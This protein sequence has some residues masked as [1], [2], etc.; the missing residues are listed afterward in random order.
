[1]KRLRIPVLSILVILALL[2]T[3]IPVPALALAGPLTSIAP[4]AGPV[5]TVVS[6]AG[7]GFTAGATDTIGWDGVPLTTTIIA[8]GGILAGAFTVPS[9]T[10]GVHVVSIIPPG[11]DT[12]T[13]TMNFTVAPSIVLSATTVQVGNSVAINGLGFGANLSVIIYVDGVTNISTSTTGTGTFSASFTVPVGAGGTHTVTVTDSAANTTNTTYNISPAVSVTPA[14]V[15]VGTQFT[16]SGSSFAASSA[17]T[18]AIDGANVTS[19]TTNTIGSFT[20]SLAA[21]PKPIGVHTIRAMDSLLS[22]ATATYMVVPS[23]T[24]TPSPFTSGSQITANGTGFAASSA[25][26]VYID[27]NVINSN[28]ATTSTVGSFTAAGLAIPKLPGGNHTLQIR[29][30]SNNSATINFSVAQGITISPQSGTAG[31][32]VQVTGAG[33]G[34]SKVITINFDSTKL[35]T[36]PAVITTDATGGFLA[37][38]AVPPSFGGPHSVVITD[39]TISATASFSIGASANLSPISGTVGTTVTVTGTSFASGGA[40]LVTYDTQSVATA[41]ASSSGAFTATFNVPASA[42]GAHTV[43]VGDGTRK[44]NFSFSVT[45]RTTI[46]PASGNVGTP[47]IVTGDGFV[48]GGKITVTYDEAQI[49]TITANNTGGWAAVFPAPVSKGGNHSIIVNDGT[50]TLVST[51]AMDSTPPPTPALL[52]PANDT[53]ADALTTFQWEAVTDPSGFTYELEVSRDSKFSILVLEKRGLTTQGYQVTELEKLESVSQQ[54]PYYWRVRAMD[55][56]SNIS[57][58]SQ[59][60]TFYV[61]FVLPMWAFYA[62][63]GGAVVLAGVLGYLLGKRRRWY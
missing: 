45:A 60:R 17:V 15:A 8:A 55:T 10:A 52:S 1:M 34:A 59:T 39:G 19:T 14:S 9:T 61:G 16:I 22:S 18:I 47:I 36:S 7:T 54:Q 43:E 2:V 11:T 21:P 37:T 23:M 38:F 44:V 12:S 50:S 20:V 4:L 25:V 30:A 53:K 58:W 27:G 3:F 29:D 51:F 56:A 49:G 40:I 35:T 32:T 33:F 48:S 26:A 41:T 6:L 24:V 28:V 57:P 42:T 31:T 5:G 63:I 62:I 46:N 13:N